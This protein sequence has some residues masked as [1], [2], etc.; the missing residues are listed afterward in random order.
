M[1]R[2]GRSWRRALAL[3]AS[4]LTGCALDLA[5]LGPEDGGASVDSSAAEDASPAPVDT[6]VPDTSPRDSGARDSGSGDTSPPP[7]D[8]GRP[9]RD[10]GPPPPPTCGV[11][12]SPCC[13]PGQTCD[14]GACLRGMC[15]SYGGAFGTMSGCSPVCQ[16]RNTYTAGCSCPRGFSPSPVMDVRASCDG[17]ATVASVSLCTS[18]DRTAPT[19]YAGAWLE[20]FGCGAGCQRANPY[21]GGCSCPFGSVAVEM[22]V[23]VT[24]SCG[25][26]PA[27]LGVCVD[28]S[29][30]AATFG[31]AYQLGAGGAPG[32]TRPNPRTGSCSCPSDATAQTM[33]VINDIPGGFTTAPIV[34]CSR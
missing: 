21:T 33:P 22:D 34:L 23:E 7:P 9:P 8:S 16:S 2:T 28:A 31:G 25:T 13:D 11:L 32:C 4:L 18:T 6:G 10:S 30:P 3:A 27:T 14:L 12:G 26:T 15:V 19:D 20:T 5:A 1:R 24:T 29:E 17:A